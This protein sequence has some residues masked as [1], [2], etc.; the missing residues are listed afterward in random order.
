MIKTAKEFIRDAFDYLSNLVEV[1]IDRSVN[2]YLL[3]YIAN[4]FVKYGTVDN[5]IDNINKWI[6]SLIK[7]FPEMRFDDKSHQIHATIDLV[8][9]VVVVDEDLMRDLNY[10]I[11][12]QQ[13]YGITV[14]M[15]NTAMTLA[16][17]FENVEKK[18]PVIKDRYKGLGSSNPKVLR[19]LVMDP[20]TRC[21]YQVYADD[22]R[23]M[24]VYDM[25]VGKD[26][27]SVKARKEM[28]M[29]FK[30]KPSDIDT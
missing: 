8:D 25:L 15:D 11:N 14:I 18:Y 4:G 19:Q 16:H 2:R 24:Q 29:N 10:I 9:Q 3:E 6:R 30:W 5:F 7:V 17:F 22:I 27:D 26:K 1:S 23:T 21:L 20:S 28:L 13:R 12:V